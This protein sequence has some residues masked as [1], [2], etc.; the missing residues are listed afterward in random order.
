VSASCYNVWILLPVES[1]G[2]FKDYLKNVAIGGTW[3]LKHAYQSG[4]YVEPVG[5]TPEPEPNEIDPDTMDSGPP[6]DAVLGTV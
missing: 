1:R 3:L 2:T 5:P 4:G 6:E